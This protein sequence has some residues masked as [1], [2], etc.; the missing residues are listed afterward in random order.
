MSVAKSVVVLILILA[1]MESAFLY[2]VTSTINYHDGYTELTIGA[3]NDASYTNGSRRWLFFY[4]SNDSQ[5]SNTNPNFEFPFFSVSPGDH[6]LGSL[7]TVCFTSVDG[8]GTLLPA[9][10]GKSYDFYGLD[11]R[12]HESNPISVVIWVKPTPDQPLTARLQTSFN[13]AF[14][15]VT[16][17]MWI[18]FGIIDYRGRHKEKMI[19]IERSA[20]L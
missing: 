3:F 12:V 14:F 9:L 10:K 15:S 11:I 18:A 1:I 20:S 16:I 19:G 7:I 17:G 6:I 8:A 2:V 5:L 4:F 13:E